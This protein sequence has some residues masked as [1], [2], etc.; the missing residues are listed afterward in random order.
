MHT[1]NSMNSIRYSVVMV[2][3]LSSKTTRATIHDKSVHRDALA[4]TADMAG[5][6]RNCNLN[7]YFQGAPDN[8]TTYVTSNKVP[9]D[10][11]CGSRS[12]FWAISAHSA[13]PAIP[14]H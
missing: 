3:T 1:S 5:H 6:H 7:D 9:S 8:S 11:L 12:P 2:A 4:K 14:I 13:M 10:D